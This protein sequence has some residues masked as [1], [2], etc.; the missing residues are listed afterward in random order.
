MY[1]SEPPMKGTRAPRPDGGGPEVTEGRLVA[2]RYR[3]VRRLAR[4]GQAA[5]YLAR[6]LPLNRQVAL[7][8]LTR[9][10]GEEG[11]DDSFEERF[12]Q[13]ART[14][15]ALDHP[16]IVTVFDYGETAD[17]QFFIAMEYVDG[18][19]FND[20]LKDGA[21]PPRRALELVLQVCEA[22]RFAHSRGVVHRDIKNSNVLVRRTEDGR[23]Q[24]KV[25][26]FGIAKMAAERD[27]GLTQAG[28][29]LGSPHFMAPEQARGSGVDQRADIY[30]VGVLIYCALAGRY[31]FTGP[32]STAILTAHLTQDPPRFSEVVPELHLPDSLERIIRRC[33][34]KTPEARYAD[35]DALIAELTVA[36]RGL[37]GL[38]TGEEI[39]TFA[40]GRVPA[41]RSGSSGARWVA[42]AIG[43]GL[44]LAFVGVVGISV[45]AWLSWTAREHGMILQGAQVVAG[46]AQPP[47]TGTTEDEG[48]SGSA[49]TLAGEGAP[50]SSPVVGS[51]AP[52]PAHNAGSEPSGAS[53]ATAPRTGRSTAGSGSRGTASSTKG[54]RSGS[55]KG[56]GAAP[57]PTSGSDEPA[58]SG[59]GEDWGTQT[60]LLDPWDE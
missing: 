30:A 22:L 12:L 55:T 1:G 37:G 47:S 39:S 44:A 57:T 28:V 5:V 17:G 21:L 24:V 60:D 46:E 49:A 50:S 15:A 43:A 58:S 23:E 19:R 14:L 33:L 8:F 56:S 7:K 54:T 18:L 16:N 48:A 42:M 59:T 27:V 9:P 13:E 38:D 11:E 4:G 34:K 35:M 10:G 20:V 32:H 51:S 26:D 3:I 53:T 45:I 2:G 41:P 6:Q 25:V 52:V 29:I 31:P 36:R 40:A